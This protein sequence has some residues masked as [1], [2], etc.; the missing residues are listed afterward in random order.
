VIKRYHLTPLLVAA[1]IAVSGCGGSDSTKAA[2][3]PAG[4]APSAPPAPKASTNLKDTKSKPTIPRPTGKP[5]TKLV[6][7]DIVVGKG[8]AAKK[9]DKLSMQYVGVTFSSGQEFDASW[10]RG[11]PLDLQ[12]GKGM[13][14]KGW[15]QGLIGI[16]PGGRRELI[17]PANLAYG[18]QGQPPTIGPNEPLVF[19]VDAL[20]VSGK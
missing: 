18:A 16:K 14:I 20:S 12:L 10:D 17:I 19:I 5:P 11:Q 9:G 13:V 7:K 4:P 2:D 3:I 1:A 15:D 8:Q 6:V